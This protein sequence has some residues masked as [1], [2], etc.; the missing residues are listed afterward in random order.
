MI[1][2]RQNEQDLPNR[3]NLIKPSA[4]RSLKMGI[5]I[6]QGLTATWRKH[7]KEKPFL[8]QMP[9]STEYFG[10]LFERKKFKPMD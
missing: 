6:Q 2:G 7:F 4:G 5:P 8:F 9:I 3:L 1:L 10:T